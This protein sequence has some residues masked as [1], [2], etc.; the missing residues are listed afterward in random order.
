[1]IV[2]TPGAIAGIPRIVRSNSD[3]YR[4]IHGRKIN[5]KSWCGFA[6]G[7]DSISENPQAFKSQPVKLCMLGCNLNFVTHHHF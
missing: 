1:M 6:G 4:R 5:I 3:I 7:Q 2:G